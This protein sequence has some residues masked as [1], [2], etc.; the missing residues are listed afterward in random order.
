MISI[1]RVKSAL[2]LSALLVVCGCGAAVPRELVDARGAV[3]RAT[4]SV[5]ARS[6]IGTTPKRPAALDEPPAA[7]TIFG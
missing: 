5:N 2:S 6:G 3:S 7:A 4:A 1:F